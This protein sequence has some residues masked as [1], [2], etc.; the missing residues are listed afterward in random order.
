MRPHLKSIKKI[1]FYGLVKTPPPPPNV[2]FFHIPSILTF[3]RSPMWHSFEA[4]YLMKR[5]GLCGFYKKEKKGGQCVN[6]L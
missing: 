4:A 6:A 5:G 2:E 3:D 1:I